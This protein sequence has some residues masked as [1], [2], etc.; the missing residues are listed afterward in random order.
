MAKNSILED[1]LNNSG[2]QGGDSYEDTLAREQA[3][4]LANKNYKDYLKN[5][6]AIT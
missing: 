5:I 2:S 6:N 1:Y 4:A 3:E